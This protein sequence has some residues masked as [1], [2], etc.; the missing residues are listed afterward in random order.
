[1][2]ERREITTNLK[3]IQTIIRTYY[4]QLYTIKFD[5]LKEMDAFLESLNYQK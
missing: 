2:N 4:K 1:M 5:N 3:E